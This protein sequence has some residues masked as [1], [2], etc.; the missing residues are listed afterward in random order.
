[1][2]FV[3]MIGNKKILWL[4]YNPKLKLKDMEENDKNA[5]KFENLHVN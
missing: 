1:M 2:V 5:G 3:F 4:L